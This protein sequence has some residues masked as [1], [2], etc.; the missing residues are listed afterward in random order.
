MSAASTLPTRSVI[1]GK[2]DRLGLD[3][4]EGGAGDRHSRESGPCAS[5]RRCP[6]GCVACSTTSGFLDGSFGVESEAVTVRSLHHSIA[7]AFG[8]LPPSSVI[9]AVR[10]FDVLK[11]QPQLPT[12]YRTITFTARRSTYST[13]ACV[14]SFD[15]ARFTTVLDAA[16]VFIGCA[17]IHSTSRK[18][19]TGRQ[20]AA[21]ASGHL[22][23]M[24]RHGL[25]RPP[26]RR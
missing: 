13:S 7:S 8:C 20:D 9:A 25:P 6:A 12:L 14:A 4:H 5:R 10:R 26:V 2:P 18:H 22:P 21:H 3:D 24:R 19:P 1:E 16:I 23:R 15:H 11:A 17:I